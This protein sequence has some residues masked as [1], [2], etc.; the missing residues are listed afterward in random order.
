MSSSPLPLQTRSRIWAT[1]KALLR[2]RIT[3]GV[4]VVLPIWLTYVIVKF[5]F[6]VMRDAS[7]W[8]LNALVPHERVVLWTQRLLVEQLPLSW[9]AWSGLSDYRLAEEIESWALSVFAVF[10]TIFVLYF[11]G[12]LTANI[13]GR[14]AIVSMETLLDRVPLVKTVYRSSKQILATFSSDQSTGYQR[15]ALVPLFADRV[16]TI[17][18]I[19]NVFRDTKSNEELCTVF[20]SSVPSPTTSYVLVLRRSDLIELEWSFEEALKMVISGGILLPGPFTI[21]AP[22]G[23]ALA[24][25]RASARPAEPPPAV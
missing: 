16:Y 21:A 3:Q 12:L 17:G 18:F 25:L 2:A 9:R 19:T 8:V 11:V 22:S 24:E 7:V 6:E 10:L 14:R 1:F 5:V 13:V 23:V 20:I 15:V 4:I